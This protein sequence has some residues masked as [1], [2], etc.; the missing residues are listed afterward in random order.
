MKMNLGRQN[1]DR[2]AQFLESGARPLE[3][4]LFRFH[5]AGGAMDNVLR[6]LS[7]YQNSDG[8]F[9][10]GSEPDLRTPDSSAIATAQTVSAMCGF[11]PSVPVTFPQRYTTWL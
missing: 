2:A 5:F 3:Q 6:E 4:A 9:G 11:F 8:G 1:F 7:P 10:H